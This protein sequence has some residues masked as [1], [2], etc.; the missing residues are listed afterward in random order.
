MTPKNVFADLP[1]LATE[2]LV[3][4]RLTMADAVDIFI[5]FGSPEVMRYLSL[6]C[7][8]NQQDSEHFLLWAIG[9]YEGHQEA[10][11]GVTLKSTGR[12]IGTCMFS[13]W[14][15]GDGR[16]ELGYMLA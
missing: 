1:N 14:I 11:W 4:R 7:H 5:C 16:A 6:N 15:I 10:P 13:N 9:C 12:L 2:R 8:E 3:L